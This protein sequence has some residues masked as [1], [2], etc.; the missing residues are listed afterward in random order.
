MRIYKDQVSLENSSLTDVD[1]AIGEFIG[2]RLQDFVDYIDSDLGSMVH[3]L[4]IEPSDALTDVDAELGFSLV[5]RPWDVVESHPG[6]YEITV[7]LSDD[8]FGWVI[9]VP[10]HAS[11]DAF[12]L[13]KCASYCQESMP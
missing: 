3:I 8:G 11:T 9:Y 2:N 5:D 13:E 4:V 10:K 7:V 6:W 1:E 12:L